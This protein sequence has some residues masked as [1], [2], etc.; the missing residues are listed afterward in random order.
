MGTTARR[1]PAVFRRL[2]AVSLDRPSRRVLAAGPAHQ[3]SDPIAEG[4]RVPAGV[5]DDYEVLGAPWGFDLAAIECPVTVWQ[6]D[7]DRLVPRSWGD[8]LAAATPH[9]DLTVL[10]G[11]GHFLSPSVYVA[12]FATLIT[13]SGRG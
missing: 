3:F 7:S 6:G 13:H 8:R 9:F 11:Q 1:A 12:I 2:S 5:L 4:L 10:A